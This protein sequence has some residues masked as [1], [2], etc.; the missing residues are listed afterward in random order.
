MKRVQIAVVG[1]G[2]AGRCAALAAASMGA[3][4]VLLDET[5]VFHKPFMDDARFGPRKE[6]DAGYEQKRGSVV[7][8]L[9]A[10]N[11]LGVVHGSESYQLQA[12]RV[13]LATGSTDQPCPF[14]GGSLPGVF[15]SRAINVLFR[16]CR[17]M[18]GRRFVV[19]GDNSDA[20]EITRTIEYYGGEV[21]A[22]VEQR[23]IP[24]FRAFG[25]EGIESVEIDGIC[26]QA[27]IVVVA[28]GRQPD[29]ELALMAECAIGYSKEL[30]GF[31][32]V[33]DKYMR[34]SNSD[35]LVAGDAAGICDVLTAATE[36]SLAGASA[37]HSLGFGDDDKLELR[38]E[39]L[40]K[41]ARDRLELAKR[42]SSIYVQV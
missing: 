28:L 4:T 27:D 32:P 24:T 36:G 42:L 22:R 41:R 26:M 5:R 1:D 11:T 25:D 16:P 38:C 29:I 40:A 23:Q 2:P 12:E 8:G 30:G 33:R 34:T 31:V 3:E 39:S 20:S 35:I 37:A 13:I 10:D 21:I 17:V 19:V 18:P 9:F 6:S 7:W 15:T 14:P